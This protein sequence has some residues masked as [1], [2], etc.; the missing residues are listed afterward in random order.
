MSFLTGK[1]LLLLGFIAVLL[2]VIP[3]TVYFLQTQTKTKTQATPATTL[4]FALKGQTQKVTT[5]TK[6]VDEPFDLDVIINPGTNQVIASTL[7]IT[8]D[9][10]KLQIANGDFRPTLIETASQTEGFT[11]IL[12]GPTTTTGAV[13]VTLTVGV[14]VTKIIKST[15]KIATIRF[16]AI[17]PGSNITIGFDDSKTN[18]TSSVDPEVNVLSSTDR[19]SLTV[20]QTGSPTATP[21]LTGSPTSTLTPIPTGPTNTPVSSPSATPTGTLTPNQLPICTGLNVDR[22]TSGAAPFSITFTANGND[23]NGTVNKVTFDFGDGPVQDVTT[24]GGIGTK[25]VSVQVAHTYNNA[26]TFKAKAILTDNNNGL[27]TV[28]DTCAQNITITASTGSG[29]TTPTATPAATIVAA[30]P[31]ELPTT[32]PAPTM[33]PGPGDTFLGIGIFG[34]G[35]AV[36]GGII[37][38]AL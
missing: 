7:Y 23:P 24:G 15:Q 28:S 10:T 33:H 20:A 30:A 14:D 27:S 34:I 5:I 36:L 32:T 4:Y 16:T 38:F 26:G 11:S 29:T 19:V 8:Y 37:F 17:A 12:A 21:T 31:T 6:N 1:K 22:I 3:L 9:S 25:T 35:L 2:A 13:S 18:V